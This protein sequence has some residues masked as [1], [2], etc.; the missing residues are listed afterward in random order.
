MKNLILI[1]CML[2]C[3]L[4]VSA[5]NK[6]DVLYL[7]NGSVIKGT[8][9][10]QVPGSHIK[11]KTAD[12]NEL[13]YPFS[14]VSKIESESAPAVQTAGA[15]NIVS[16]LKNSTYK[17]ELVKQMKW[18]NLKSILLQPNDPELNKAVNQLI[19]KQTILITGFVI[20]NVLLAVSL[21]QMISDNE[22]IRSDGGTAGIGLV[23]AGAGVML[24]SAIAA[25]GSKRIF[26]NA[27]SRYNWVTGSTGSIEIT[28]AVIHNR[29]GISFAISKK[30]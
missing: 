7:K 10:E 22:G 17:G 16:P 14:D 26:K 11:I 28:P 13:Q 15:F 19:T 29:P 1:L 27:M 20:G 21:A 5:Q 23:G 4:S 2:T 6:R 24:V 9:T 25:S 3:S 8:V 12:G 18:K 30:F